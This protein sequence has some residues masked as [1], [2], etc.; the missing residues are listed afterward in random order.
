[1]PTKEQLTPP[2]TRTIERGDRFFMRDNPG[3]ICTVIGKVYHEDLSVSYLM[4]YESIHGDPR[5]ER[6]LTVH[7]GSL[8][9]WPWVLAWRTKRTVL[10][11][12]KTY[13]GVFYGAT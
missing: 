8:K 1:M 5:S 10:M 11:T 3:R 7:E 9:K 6:H 4:L 2:L 12:E 13:S